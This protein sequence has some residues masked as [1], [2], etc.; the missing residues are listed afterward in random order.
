[1]KESMLEGV[2]QTARMHVCVSVCQSL[3][4]C[5]RVHIFT[6]QFF[7]N[8]M[9]SKIFFIGSASCWHFGTPLLLF[10]GKEMTLEIYFLES[11]YI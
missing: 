4:V 9:E 2:R 1:M 7:I 3:F 6:V 11:C 8:I 5:I 10:V